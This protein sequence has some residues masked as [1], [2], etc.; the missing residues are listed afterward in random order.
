MRD[1]STPTRL[2]AV[3]ATPLVRRPN[4]PTSLFNARRTCSGTCGRKLGWSVRSRKAEPSRGPIPNRACDRCGR[5]FK[6]SH[7][8]VRFCSVSCGSHASAAKRHADTEWGKRVD[9]TCDHCGTVFIAL[10]SEL[11]S[12]TGYRKRFC[13]EGCQ[14]AARRLPERTIVCAH[15]GVEF[16]TRKQRART[17]CS[18]RC[19]SKAYIAIARNRISRLEGDLVTALQ[20]I[21]HDVRPQH[22]IGRFTVDAFLPAQQLAVECFGD[23]FHCNPAKYPDGPIDAIQRKNVAGD[24]KRL[25]AMAALGIRVVI[26]WEADIA[27]HGFTGAL[28]RVGLGRVAP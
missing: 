15:C 11:M 1:E 25:A 14:A 22:R 2:C 10:A 23:Y 4:E 26:V 16:T 20:D 19:V 9:I 18:R 28:E 13:S 7:R 27:T 17:Y 21:G 8:T 5:E 24:Q 6:P 3:C 12:R